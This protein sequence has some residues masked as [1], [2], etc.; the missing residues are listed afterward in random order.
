MGLLF[1][2]L[3]IVWE[4]YETFVEVDMCEIVLI[5]SEGTGYEFSAAIFI[6]LLKFWCEVL[7]IVLGCISMSGDASGE[8]LAGRRIFWKLKKLS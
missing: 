3:K 5:T 8:Q 7:T 6:D 1:E 4:F 2:F